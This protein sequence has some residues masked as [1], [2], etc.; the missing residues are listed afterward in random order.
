MPAICPEVPHLAACPVILHFSDAFT[1][2]CRFEPHVVVDIDGEFDRLVAMLHCHESQFYEWLPYNAGYPDE[3]P[4]GDDARREW[5]AGRMRQRLEP[6]ADRY[7]DLLVRTY[8]DEHGGARPPRRG[9]RGLG[10][11]RAARRR[12]P[13]PVV[14]V[15]ARRFPGGLAVHPEAV[16]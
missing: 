14:P 11:R 2:P 16:G 13:R 12:R 1:R 4:Q 10:V 9:L 6:L 3:V 5:L 7:R 8:G 15:P